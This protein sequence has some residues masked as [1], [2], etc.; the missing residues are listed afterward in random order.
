MDWWMFLHTFV[1]QIVLLQ[2]MMPSMPLPQSNKAPLD[3]VM[4]SRVAPLLSMIWELSVSMILFMF[5]VPV[6]SAAWIVSYS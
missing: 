3:Q 5:I 1:P 6:K 2:K 4:A